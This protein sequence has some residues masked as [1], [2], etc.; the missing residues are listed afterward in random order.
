MVGDSGKT[1]HQILE[2]CSFVQKVQLWVIVKIGIDGGLYVDRY[3]L[4]VVC[5]IRELHS[6]HRR[7]SAQE[8]VREHP[9]KNSLKWWTGFALDWG[10]VEW[11]IR[12]CELATGVAKVKSLF[13]NIF[14]TSCRN[15][16]LFIVH[17]TNNT[18]RRS[19]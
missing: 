9:G 10:F 6:G 16:H 3:S 8:R 11:H 5:L 1:F 17:S 15:R 7:C 18:S 14:L 12:R 13:I 2:P 4:L 19:P